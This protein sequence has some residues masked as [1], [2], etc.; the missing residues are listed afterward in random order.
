M[1]TI[2]S[3]KDF[4]LRL[5]ALDEINGALNGDVTQIDG[6]IQ[7]KDKTGFF[8]DVHSPLPRVKIPENQQRRKRPPFP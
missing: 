3:E 6:A 2:E 4:F 8:R 1:R 7:I 5:M